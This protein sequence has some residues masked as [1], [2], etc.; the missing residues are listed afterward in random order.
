MGLPVVPEETLPPNPDGPLVLPEDTV[1]SDSGTFL[2][3]STLALEALVISIVTP[4]QLPPPQDRVFLDRRTDSWGRLPEPL[5]G[6]LRERRDE[7]A[8]IRADI[9]RKAVVEVMPPVKITGDAWVSREFEE[10]VHVGAGVVEVG[11][12]MQFGVKIAGASALLADVVE[13]REMLLH[14]FAHCLWLTRRVLLAGV[15]PE[16]CRGLWLD[17]EMFDDPDFEES[18]ADRPGDWFGADDVRL[19][20]WR[21]RDVFPGGSEAIMREWLMP[22]LPCTLAPS[23]YPLG[24]IA[25]DPEIID[26]CEYLNARDLSQA[27]SPRW[28]WG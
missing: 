17:C 19:Y 7:I 15:P 25:I 10:V 1:S 14:G 20:K 6:Q 18:C 21:A 28:N 4:G 11:R 9:A 3:H 23:T 22:N 27:R 8:A 2:V 16:E 13:L 5:R 24:V 12:A 26:H